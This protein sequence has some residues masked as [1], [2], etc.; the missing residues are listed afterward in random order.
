MLKDITKNFAIR[1][2]DRYKMYK[3]LI[4]TLIIVVLVM[5]SVV[6]ISIYHLNSKIAY[7]EVEIAGLEYSLYNQV[8]YSIFLN[9]VLEVNGVESEIYQDFLEDYLYPNGELN[10]ELHN[11][12]IEMGY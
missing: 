3:I 7:N 8:Q 9:D 5:V 6:C 2:R 11:K 1:N 12:F 10:Q 4:I